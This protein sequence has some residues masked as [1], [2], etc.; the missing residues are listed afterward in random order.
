MMNARKTIT[1]A[2]AILLA[3]MLIAALAPKVTRGVVAA[4]IRDVDQAAR[5]PFSTSCGNPNPAATTEAFVDC[6]TPA[7]P[8]GEEVVIENVS[9]LAIGEH[10]NFGAAASV[11]ATEGSTVHSFYLNPMFDS[12]IAQPTSSVIQGTQ[13]VR[14]YADP[15][16]SIDCRVTTTGANPSGFQVNCQFSGYYVSLP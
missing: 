3:A 4:F 10:T 7:I 9:I 12:D 14:F 5:H 1:A 16:T 6:S 13:A 8:A 15:G 2:G 11:A